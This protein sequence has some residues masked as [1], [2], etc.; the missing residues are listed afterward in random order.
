[1]HLHIFRYFS[2]GAVDIY[3]CHKV[4]VSNCTLANNGPVIAIKIDK[5]RGHAGGLS[6]AY[7]YD[8]PLTGV[9]ISA[10]LT[11]TSFINNRAQPLINEIGTTSRLLSLF[12]FIGRGGGCAININSPTRVEIT[13][14]NCVFLKNYASYYGG[15]LYLVFGLVSSH[16]VTMRDSELIENQTPLGAGGLSIAFVLGGWDSIANKVFVLSV[17]FN[18]NRA[19]FGS[20]THVFFGGK[21]VIL[22]MLYCLSI[23]C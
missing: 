12:I 7:N 20:G 22:S 10:T 23:P 13:V 11:D 9:N 16:T 21:E 3:N 19:L 2:Q 17:L 5:W 8:T 15:G 14:K 4:L 18:K 1:M 6:I